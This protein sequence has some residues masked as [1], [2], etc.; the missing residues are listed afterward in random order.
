MCLIFLTRQNIFFSSHLYCPHGH[1]EILVDD[2]LLE[3]SPLV[4][5]TV[6]VLHRVELLGGQQEL[7]GDVAWSRPH[8]PPVRGLEIGTQ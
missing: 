1:R 5:V 3:E 7:L 8:R 2:D 4:L 6:A